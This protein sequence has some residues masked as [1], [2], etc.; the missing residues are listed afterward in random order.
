M[1]TGIYL[2]PPQ[3]SIDIWIE[4]RSVSIPECGCIVFLGESDGAGY[5]R[6]SRGG[7]KR[8]RIQRIIWELK[9]GPIPDGMNVLHRC[10]TP[11]CWNPHH[12]FLGTR[13]DN[14]HDK[15]LKGRYRGVHGE[16][17]GLS[18]LTDGRVLEIR[19]SEK[20]GTYFADKFNVSVST[21][22]RIR[23]SKTWK[24]IGGKK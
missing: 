3:Q 21:I 12:L 4:N 20:S 10:D 2:R 15:M 19:L 22:S 24:H 14:N 8:R 17:Q 5:G 13:A 6:T 9:H 7:G 16:Q 18:K 1:P 11:P 23:S